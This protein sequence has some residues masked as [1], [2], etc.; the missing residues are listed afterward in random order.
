MIDLVINIVLIVVPIMLGYFF[1]RRIER[2]HY[3]SIR[4][5]EAQ[6]ASLMTTAL[7]QPL[8]PQKVVT[9][10]LVSGSVVISIDYFKRFLAGLRNFFGGN[11]T[12]Y[13]SLVDRARREAIL[14]MKESAAGADEIINIR[15]ETSSIS[16]NSSKGN[17]GSVEVLAYGTA[18]KY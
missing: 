5:R 4:E 10:E 12:A 1:G 15:I 16:K 7:K 3:E 6:F 13:E 14:R 11:I 17:I 8:E 2:R 9:A 18:L